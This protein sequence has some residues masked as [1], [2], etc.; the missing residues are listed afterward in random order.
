ML[1]LHF[2]PM[3]AIAQPT[4]ALLVALLVAS[5]GQAQH[6]HVHGEGRLDVSIE[7]GTIA[8]DLQLPLDSAV[9]FELAPKNDRELAAL[10]AAQKALQAAAALWLPTAAAQCT[11]QSVEVGMPKFDGSPHADVNARYV[12]RCTQPAALQGIETT[13]F[14]QFKRLHRLETQRI[15][16]VGQGAQRLTPSRPVLAW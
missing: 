1:L 14:Q 2:V 10:A 5:T 15:G 8:L 11:V 4:T 7:Q 9:G 13:L 3:K 6:K 12:F 16:P